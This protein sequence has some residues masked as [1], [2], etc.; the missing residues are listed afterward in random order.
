MGWNSTITLVN[1]AT[2]ADLARLGWRVTDETLDWEEATMSAHEGIAAWS[3]GD[4]LVL[5]SGGPELIESTDRLAALGP[6]R[7]G[8]FSSVS[9]TYVWRMAG[10]DQQ[11]EWVW[12][13]DEQVLDEGEPHPEEAALDSLDEDNLFHL[14][15]RVGGLRFDEQ[16]EEARFVVVD[17][18]GAGAAPEPAPEPRKKGLRRWFG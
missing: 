2:L 7:A 14:L 1:G 17:A 9:D 11:R 5:A 16:L 6:V 13:A 4:T 15:E 8:M 12:S 10:P 18:D 3:Q